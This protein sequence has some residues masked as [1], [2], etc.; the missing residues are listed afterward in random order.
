YEQYQYI[1]YCQS[2]KLLKEYPI[3]ESK[4]NTIKCVYIE[5]T[6]VR[7]RLCKITMT[8]FDGLTYDI[9]GKTGKLKTEQSRHKLNN[10][11]NGKFLLQMVWNSTLKRIKFNIRLLFKE[12]RRQ[13][14]HFV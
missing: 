1:R 10:Q 7:R 5:V 8:R 4:I 9:C 2:V 13:E 14:T 12:S 6:D 11:S 3:F